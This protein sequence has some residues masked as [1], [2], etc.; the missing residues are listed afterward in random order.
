MHARA[1]GECARMWLSESPAD[2]VNLVIINYP[3]M[4]LGVN[5]VAFKKRI[6]LLLFFVLSVK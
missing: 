1:S 5:R 3:E 6:D 4:Y 2:T